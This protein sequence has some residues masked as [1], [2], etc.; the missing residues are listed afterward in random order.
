MIGFIYQIGK[1]IYQIGKNK[2]GIDLKSIPFFK[3]L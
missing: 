3:T 2:K 1:P